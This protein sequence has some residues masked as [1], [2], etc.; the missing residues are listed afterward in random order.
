[1]NNELVLSPEDQPQILSFSTPSTV[2]YRVDHFFHHDL[3]LFRVIKEMP[4]EDLTEAFC[5]QVSC[6]EHHQRDFTFVRT[7]EVLQSVMFVGSSVRSCV[8]EHV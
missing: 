8:G 5:T 4:P 7:Q 3:G 1:M 2:H 6:S